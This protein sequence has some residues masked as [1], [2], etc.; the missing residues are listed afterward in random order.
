MGVE[1]DSSLAISKDA[2]ATLD[3]QKQK[4]TVTYGNLLNQKKFVSEDRYVS[5]TRAY[6]GLVRSVFQELIS[7]NS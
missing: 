2:S 5:Y 4:I 7:F 1:V 3:I 6:H